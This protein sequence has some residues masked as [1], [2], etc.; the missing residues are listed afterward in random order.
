MEVLRAAIDALQA[1]VV[2]HSSSL[3]ARKEA[4]SVVQAAKVTFCQ[5]YYGL[6]CQV[7][8]VVGDPALARSYFRH[9]RKPSGQAQADDPVD[10]VGPSELSPEVT[11]TGVEPAQAA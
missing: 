10:V 5:R 1:A 7:V 8:Q 6:F 4:W 9:E 2:D 11:D 3:R